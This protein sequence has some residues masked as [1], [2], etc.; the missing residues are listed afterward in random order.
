MA[1]CSSA[2]GGSSTTSCWPASC[3]RRSCA[4]R[5]PMRRYARSTCV[6][7]WHCQVSMQ[8]LRSTISRRS[9]PSVGCCATPIPGRRS[10]AI[11]RSRSP[12]ARCPTSARLSRWSWPKAAT[13][14]RTRRR[15]W[16]WTTTCFPPL[17]IAAR[18]LSQ[19]HPRCGVSSTPMSPP[20]TRS[21]TATPMRPLTR[22]RM[23]STKNFGS[24]AAP[25]IR[26]KVAAFSRNGAMT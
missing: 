8:C 26:S 1:P 7:P 14:P 17:R 25:P 11:G 10:T 19:P 18:R 6:T 3:T 16:P 5:T 9:W 21:S 24:I 22:L 13:S 12:T 20:P 23:S 15:S 2:R 4:A